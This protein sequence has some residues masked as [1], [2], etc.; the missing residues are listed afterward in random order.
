MNPVHP[1]FDDVAEI[2][3]RQ[4]GDTE[5]LARAMPVVEAWL[6]APRVETRLLV[7]L[8][9]ELVQRLEGQRAR[10]R[11]SGGPGETDLRPLEYLMLMAMD[12][13]RADGADGLAAVVARGLRL[14]GLHA[15]GCLLEGEAIAAPTWSL[16][17]R[18]Y[19]HA[20]AGG[21]AAAAG[22]LGVAPQALYVR[23][24]LL[25][26]LAGNGMSPRQI[27]KCFDWMEQWSRGLAP[28]AAR[29]PVRHYFAVDLDG[30]AGLQEPAAHAAM[31]AP[32]FLDHVALAERVA[33]ARAEY[34]RQ[35]SVSTLGLYDTNPLF[36]YHEALFQLNR[37]WDYVGVRQSGRDTGR[38]QTEATQVTAVAG[39]DA[40][41]RVAEGGEGGHRWTLIDQSPTGA[42]FRVQGVAMG[43]EKGA[44]TLF[45][46]PGGQGWVLGSSVRVAASVQGLSVGVKRLA[47][48]WRP[49]RL[50]LEDREDE[51]GVFGFFIFGD[52]ARG[53]ADSIIV[54]NGTFDPARTFTMRP[55]GDLFRIR[56]SRVIQAAGDWERVGFDVL[57]RLSGDR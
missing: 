28:E 50:K 38:R 42:G 12:R 7:A 34:F 39:F 13:M 19:V 10:R 22:E 25:S 4:L 26:T 21:D 29:D 17:H 24:L 6:T 1:G 44:L 31:T 53:L 14:S 27:D 47:D 55:G 33:L 35:I 32:R 23:M 15:L 41:A 18:M 57:K 40:C 43:L 2:P 36:E 11:R 8:D 56:L 49:V 9:D 46:G 45:A 48:D 51:S 52:E 20:E 54:R 16:A 37:Y 3:W 30:G 5:F